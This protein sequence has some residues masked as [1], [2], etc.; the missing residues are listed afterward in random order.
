MSFNKLTRMRFEHEILQILQEECAEVIQA[1]SKCVRFGTE[2]NLLHLEREIGDIVCILDIM[3]KHDMVSH[4]KL[5]EYVAEKYEKLEKY[6]NIVE[7]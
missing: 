4:T 6:S 2:E 1:A 7:K 3:H 5:D